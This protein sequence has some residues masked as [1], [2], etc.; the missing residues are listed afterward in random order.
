MAIIKHKAMKN[1]DYNAAIEYLEYEHDASGKTI[2][3]AYGLPQQ[4]E[5]YIMNG[6][7]LLRISELLCIQQ[8]KGTKSESGIARITA[9]SF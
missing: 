2:K 5:H 4:R 8:R 9:L 1:A 7:S 6:I 3:D